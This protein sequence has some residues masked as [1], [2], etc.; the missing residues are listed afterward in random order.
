MGGVIFGI[1]KACHPHVFRFEWPQEVQDAFDA[2]IITI[3]DLEMAGLLLLWLVMEGCVGSDNLRHEHVCLLSDNS[4]S[5]GWIDRLSSKHSEIAARILRALTIR[6]R[7][8]RTS[9]ITPLHIPGVHNTIADIPSRSFGY[10][11]EWHFVEDLDFLQFFNRKI[12][13]GN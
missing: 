3:P 1:R 11:K 5:I 8:C 7:A 10:K 13:I 12:Q 9:P 6:M 4:P 2:N